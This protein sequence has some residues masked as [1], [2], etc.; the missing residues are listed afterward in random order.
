MY[1]QTSIVHYV[2]TIVT[3]ESFVAAVNVEIPTIMLFRSENQYPDRSIWFSPKADRY[4][5]VIYHT[6]C[7]ARQI[8]LRN[9]A[10][11]GFKV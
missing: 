1:I 10:W 5:R 11:H 2:R 6:K 3:V 7:I 8:H 4:D 9:T